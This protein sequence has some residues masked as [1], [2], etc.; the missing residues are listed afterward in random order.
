MHNSQLYAMSPFS[1]LALWIVTPCRLPG[2][3]TSSYISLKCWYIST[4]T[5]SITTQN[6]N[7]D[8]LTATKTSISYTYLDSCEKKL[9]LFQS[10]GKWFHCTDKYF[11]VSLPTQKCENRLFSKYCVYNVCQTVGN[12]KHNN[13]SVINHCYKSYKT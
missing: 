13:C 11:L 6:T 3:R 10:S 1:V 8:I 7:T 4:S 2:W 9:V 5:H 12:A